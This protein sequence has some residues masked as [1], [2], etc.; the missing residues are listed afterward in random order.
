MV[1]RVLRNAQHAQRIG[2]GLFFVVVGGAQF[3]VVGT[4]ALA[5]L[6]TQLGLPLGFLLAWLI[7]FVEI[8]CGVAL[9]CQYYVRHTAWPLILISLGMA[10]TL[11][12]YG[13]GS[14]QGSPNWIQVVMHVVLALTLFVLALSAKR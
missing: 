3:L 7:P 10:F 5:L 11:Y 4:D 6:F 9:M 1:D 14:L 8:V 13:P 2:L 12:W